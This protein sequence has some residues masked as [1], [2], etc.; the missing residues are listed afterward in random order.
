M[1]WIGQGKKSHRRVDF[2]LDSGVGGAAGAGEG[3]P[4]DGGAAAGAPD[5]PP[6][7]V[8]YETSAPISAAFTLRGTMPAAFIWVVGTFRTVVS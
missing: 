5:V 2:F 1:P 3:G 8:T 4:A 6:R 7:L